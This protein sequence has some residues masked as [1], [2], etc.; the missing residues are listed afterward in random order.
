VITLEPGQPAA[1]E[2]TIPSGLLRIAWGT[3]EYS[4]DWEMLWP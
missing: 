1:G 4:T 2:W 3:A